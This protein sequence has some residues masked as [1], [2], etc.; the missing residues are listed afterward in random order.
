MNIRGGDKQNRL[1]RPQHKLPSK[2]A[3]TGTPRVTSIQLLTYF[4]LHRLVSSLAMEYEY[5]D[6]S[7]YF[8]DNNA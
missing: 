3:G 4:F 7:L 2:P 6:L 1:R 5:Y 8:V